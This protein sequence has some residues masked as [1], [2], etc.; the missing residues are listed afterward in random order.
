M[1]LEFQPT[2]TNGTN[3]SASAHSTLK[4]PTSLLEMRLLPAELSSSLGGV[5]PSR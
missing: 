1:L 5:A 3:A 2:Y 4:V